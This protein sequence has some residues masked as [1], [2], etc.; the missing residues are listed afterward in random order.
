VVGG[1][2]RDALLGRAPAD[3]DLA[4]DARPERMLEI[5]PGAAYENR[6]GTVAV[7]AGGELF[8]ITTFRS[9]HDYADFRRPHRVEFGDSI[10][11]DLARRDFTVNAMAWGADAPHPPS[12]GAGAELAGDGLG[13]LERS[14]AEASEGHGPIPGPHLVDPFGG[15]ADASARVL[16]AVGDPLARFEEDALRMIRAVRLATALGFTIEPATLDAIRA[17][18]DRASHLSGER[19]AAELERLLATPQPSTGLDLLARTGLLAAILPELA[20]QHGIGQ[21]KVEGE[22]L[23][24]HTLRTVD[25]AP[26][27]RPVVRRAAL[28][29]DIG[30]PATR[31]EAGFPGHQTV[32]ASMAAAVLERLRAPRSLAERVVHLVRNHM[33]SYESGWSDAA[34]RRFIAR[35]GPTAIDELLELRQADNVGSGQPHDGGLDELRQRIAD[36]LAADVAL[37]RSDLAVDGRDLIA[38]LGLTPGPALGQVL[39]ELL[40]RVVADPALN[41]RPTLLLL[42]QSMLA[43]ES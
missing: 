18:A 26:A 6:F 21:N 42:A 22:D 27:D 28:L 13:A 37:D 5:F 2:L 43:D 40:E 12:I 9:E 31:S 4:T 8:E 38:E 11:V 25:A 19:I 16:R 29:H 32:G 24:T 20:A 1:S 7:R 36:Q 30:K 10:V 34:V 15:R 17:R 35:I 33:F 14:S 23:W 39:D 41:D 3:W